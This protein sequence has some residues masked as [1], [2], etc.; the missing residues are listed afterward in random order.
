MKKESNEN[1]ESRRRLPKCH[2]GYICLFP[3]FYRPVGSIPFIILMKG[4]EEEKRKRAKIDVDDSGSGS[5]KQK[6]P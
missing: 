4:K 5:R 3:I 6:G 1:S 2:T